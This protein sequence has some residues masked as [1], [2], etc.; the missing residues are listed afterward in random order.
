[1]Q[2][3]SLGLRDSSRWVPPEHCLTQALLAQAGVASRAAG[4]GAEHARGVG[5]RCDAPLPAVSRAMWIAGLPWRCRPS[6]TADRLPLAARSW[7]HG[8]GQAGA[9]LPTALCP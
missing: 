7:V 4:A 1:M 2:V 9:Q 5:A 6:L 8:A 3:G